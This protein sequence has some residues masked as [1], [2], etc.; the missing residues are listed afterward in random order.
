M[1]PFLLCNEMKTVKSYLNVEYYFKL[2]LIIVFCSFV[3]VSL[4]Y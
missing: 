3:T 1:R 2:S 4:V